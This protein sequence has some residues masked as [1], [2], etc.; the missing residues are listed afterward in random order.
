MN[1]IKKKILILVANKCEEGEVVIP[2][3]IWKRAG[4]LVELVSVH[5]EKAVIGQSRLG[6]S[7]DLTLSEV[8][9]TEF[10]LI[11]IPGG[12]GHVEIQSSVKAMQLINEFAKQNKYIAAMCAGPVIIS[13]L[14]GNREAVCFPSMKEQMKNWV[15]RPVVVSDI[16]ITGKALG[17]IFEFALKV[18]EVLDGSQKSEWLKHNIYFRF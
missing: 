6:F 7:T 14:I 10:D 8:S 17:C 16:F 9:S 5:E 4:F 3:D 13:D 1:E 12:H 18:V 11:F 15:D 2:Y